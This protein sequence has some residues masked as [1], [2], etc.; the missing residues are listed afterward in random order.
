M[1]QYLL[2]LSVK[3]ANSMFKNH[4]FLILS[5]VLSAIFSFHNPIFAQETSQNNFYSF[6]FKDTL[7]DEVDF[8]TFKGKLVLLVNIAT[9]CG[10]SDQL[11]ELQKLNEAYKSKGLIVLGVPSNDF[12]SQ[13][14][15]ANKEVGEICQRKYQTTFTILEKMVVVGD[16]KNELFQWI[17]KQKGYEGRILWNFEK[18]LINQNGELIERFRSMTSPTD[19]AIKKLIEKNLPSK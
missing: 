9:K 19:E 17:H 6:K 13:T 1:P 15:E 5:L 2:C 8:S 16:K 10:F 3:S 18:F 4:S 14:P 11:S 12:M 7:G